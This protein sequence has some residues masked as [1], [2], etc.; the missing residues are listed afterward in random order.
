MLISQKSNHNDLK[1]DQDPNH[2]H[3]L[4]LCDILIGG[5]RFHAC[6]GDRRHPRFQMSYHCKVL[7]EH[8]QENS[9]RMAQSRYFNGFSLQQA[10]IENDE[11]NFAPLVSARPALRTL[12]ESLFGKNSTV[13]ERQLVEADSSASTAKTA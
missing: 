5:F 6:F 4:Q 13:D 8:E 12:Q 10:W 7:L 3:L 9:A 2:S 11:W 1:P